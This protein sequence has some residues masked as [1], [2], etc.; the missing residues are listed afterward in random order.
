M[1]LL[2]RPG[3]AQSRAKQFTAANISYHYLDLNELPR[4]KALLV[5]FDGGR[6]KASG[7][8]RETAL[9][10]SAVNYG[11]K[12]I[13]IDQSA[14][15]ISDSAYLRIRII[16][17]HVMKEEG[18]PANLFIGGFSLG[19]YTAIRFAEMAV[20]K[21]DTAMIPNAIFAIDPPLDHL[22]FI[23]YCQRELKRKCPDGRASELGKAE[24][25][26]IL[27]YY[28]ENFGDYHED[29]SAYIGN[30]CYTSI[31]PDGGNARYL[32]EIPVNM[33]HEIDIMWLIRERCRDLSDANA[34]ISSKFV[35]CLY[36]MGNREA[37][38][39]QSSVRGYRADGRRH[40]HSWSIADPIA[41]LDW[42][43]KYLNE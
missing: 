8:S 29:S 25:R 7:I 42:L 41:T 13:G 39:T 30:S 37:T 24:A 20:A 40:P 38:I 11:Y 3:S 21:N 43:S 9:P 4:P 1:L 27:N 14:F 33:I 6:G 16:I 22:D 23:N 34:V 32:K 5:L 12:S 15:F 2:F 28:Y 26:W 31:L 10:D 19:G 17:H 18:I 35:N 36:G